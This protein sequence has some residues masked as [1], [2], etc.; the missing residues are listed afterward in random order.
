[1][2]IWRLASCNS[3]NS[4]TSPR[5]VNGLFSLMVNFSLYNLSSFVFNV[6]WNSTFFFY[7]IHQ[8]YGQHAL[9][10]AVSPVS[11]AGD[12]SRAVSEEEKRELS[13]LWLLCH[14]HVSQHRSPFSLFQVLNILLLSQTSKVFCFFLLIPRNESD[15]PSIHLRHYFLR[16]GLTDFSIFGSFRKL[17]EVHNNFMDEKDRII[18]EIYNESKERARWLWPESASSASLHTV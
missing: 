9:L 1:M 17:E 18:T 8:Q 13:P 16:S 15:Y 11:H 4:C 10:G 5:C 2:K 12:V 3:F 14:C 6:I 7:S